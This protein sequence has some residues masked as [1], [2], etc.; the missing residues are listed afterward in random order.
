MG[1][2]R[3]H[4]IRLTLIIAGIAV[5]AAWLVFL[6]TSPRE[7]LANVFGV[8]ETAFA[9]SRPEVRSEMTVKLD[10]GIKV[11]VTLPRGRPYIPGARV[12]LEITAIGSG[13]TRFYVYKFAGYRDSDGKPLP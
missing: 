7:K 12:E 3:K 6:A 11:V 13:D 10:N 9:P 5:I 1:W 8:A 2:Q 4:L